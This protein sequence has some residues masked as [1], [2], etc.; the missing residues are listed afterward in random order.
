MANSLAGLCAIGAIS[1]V[2]RNPFVWPDF[3]PGTT[4]ESQR[5]SPS[6]QGFEFHAVYEISGQTK[7][8]VR[9]R[10]NN[11]YHWLEVGKEME[12]LLAKSFDPAK[13]QLVFAYEN[14]EQFLELKDKPEVTSAPLSTGLQPTQ[15]PAVKPATTT[16]QRPVVTSRSTIAR[17]TT[18]SVNKRVSTGATTR[19]TMP[20]RSVRRTP[21]QPS[22]KDI[23]RFKAFDIPRPESTEV[24]S[25]GDLKPPAVET[26]SELD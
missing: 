17:R 5:N 1:L 16:R 13:N 8:L 4:A 9:E 6:S 11:K 23:Q 19:S 7:V 15:R 10:A 2:D 3:S 26:P 18:P 24:P 21:V 25:L 20:R 14:G 22:E 12:G